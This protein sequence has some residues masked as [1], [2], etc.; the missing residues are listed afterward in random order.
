MQ[1]CLCTCVTTEIRRRSPVP[2]VRSRRGQEA[3]MAVPHPQPDS[4]TAA[5]FSARWT[6]LATFVAPQLHA[7]EQVRAILSKSGGPHALLDLLGTFASL[8]GLAD[9]FATHRAIVLSDRRVFVV[10]MP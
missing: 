4:S 1:R 9:S 8:Y 7:G 6:R 10:R 2:T 5:G 3:S